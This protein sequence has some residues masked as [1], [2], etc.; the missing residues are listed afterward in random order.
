M[1]MFYKHTHC[2]A[3][4]EV[5]KRASAKRT[6]Y[7]ETSVLSYLTNRPSR[8]A[9]VLG[10]QLLTRQWWEDY[11]ADYHLV[12]SNFVLDEVSVG[13]P[14]PVARRLDAMRELDL[15][16]HKI[17]E[18]ETLANKLIAE[19]ALP[20]NAKLDAL[21]I[22]TSACHRVDYLAS[23][24]FSHIVNVQQ[25][26]NIEAICK[27]HGYPASRLVTLDQLMAQNLST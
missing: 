2:V 6:V 17:P 4:N 12:A 24:N 8:D 3:Y 21:H 23:W 13:H 9:I 1:I 5:M 11:R 25:M 15:L 19:K 27:A 14:E 18:I 7:I 20:A 16:D 26:D 10:R 22:A